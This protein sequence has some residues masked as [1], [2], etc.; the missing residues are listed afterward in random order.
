MSRTAFVTSEK[1]TDLPIL[2]VD[3]EGNIGEAL[4]KELRNESLVIYVSK[5]TPEILENV[6]HVPFLKKIPTIPDNRYSH[7]F[8]IDENIDL[9]NDLIEEF[10]KKSSND[11]SF[12]NLIIG[13]RSSTR[14]FIN[15]NV[16][17]YDKEKIIVFGEI[18]KS[19]TVYDRNASINKC[20]LQANT[21]GRLLITGDGTKEIYPIFF[22]DLIQGI[23]ES[24]FGADEKQNI[25]YLFPK[26]GV[27]LLTLANILKKKNPDLKLDFIKGSSRKEEDVLPEID[28][29]YLLGENYDLEDRIKRVEF[30]QIPGNDHGDTRQEKTEHDGESEKVYG[31]KA[32]FLLLMFV[33]LLPLI[34]TILFSL[35]G[36]SSLYAVKNGV[37]TGNLSLSKNLASLASGSF[38]IAQSSALVLTEE[39]GIVGQGDKIGALINGINSGENISVSVLSLIDASDKF[40]SI[41]TGGSASPEVSFSD[42]TVELKNALYLYNKEEQKGVIPKAMVEKL[43]DSIKIVSST[44]DLWHDIFGFSGSKT[45][46]IL[47]QNN[48]ELRPGGGFIGS[49]AILTVNK[50][51]ITGFN[52]YDVY[53]ADGQLKGHVE[54]PYPVRR[55]LSTVHWFLRDSNFNVDFSKGAISSAL[56]LN[57]EMHQSVDGI[58]GVDLSFVKSIL[59]VL[60]PVKVADYNQT[61]NADNFYQ[62]TQAH[63]EKDF[64]PGSVQKKDFLNAFYN[65]LESKASSVKNLPYLS[66]IQTVAKAIYEKHILFAF[67]SASQQAT[68]SVNG[69]SSALVDERPAGNSIINDFTGVNEA[70]MGGNKV[71]YYVSRSTS[72]NIT[73]D[74]KGSINEELITDIKNS[75]PAN[76]GSAGIYKN[77]VRFVLPLNANLLSVEINGREQKIIPA[78]TDPAIY[79]KKGFVPPDGLEVQKDNQGPNTIYGFLVNVQPQTAASI[80]I[81]Y[82]LAQQIN[83]S[84]PEINYNLKIF[85]QPGVDSYPYTLS[86]NFPT[87]LKVL[88]SSA[89]VKTNGSTSSL[90]TQ[91]TRDREVAIDLVAK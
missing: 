70:N 42:A 33:I 87:A 23:L 38:A 31:F 44:I 60:G 48:M 86:L 68:F 62:I 1:K 5:K 63:T 8:V 19:D 72:Q 55:Y 17:V 35:I 27:T 20:I 54:P 21:K 69:W 58:V 24:A 61:V 56:F 15:N 7:I 81:S 46:F 74:D 91:I 40:K 14:E 13:L 51:K 78:I 6:V 53:D 30:S 18:F 67:N 52:V 34:S 43:G 73:I 82:V 29:A 66:L 39:A 75:A 47:F 83:V 3:R 4:V 76:L 2:V 41:L 16:N 28:G 64:F 11:G 57:T 10:V 12:L 37:D 36:L 32:L 26:H 88:D 90:S 79:E 9:T 65:S 80:Q 85:K 77:Y 59:S 71:N 45:Y 22:D 49:Y 25:V 84:Q 89:D 50:G